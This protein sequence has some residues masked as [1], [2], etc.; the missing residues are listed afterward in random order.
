[1]LTLQVRSRT[2]EAEG[3]AGLVLT[4]P[5]GG[6]L[7]EW[8]PGAHIDVHIER[9]GA[10]ALV[11][12]YSLCGSPS[13][14]GAYRIAVLR[15]PEG[16]GGSRHLHDAVRQGQ[17]VRVSEPRNLFAYAAE[18]RAT[19]IAGGIGITPILPM[20]EAAEAAG[21]EWTLHYAG[22][23]PASMAFGRD[24][25]RY[26]ERVRVYASSEGERMAVPEIVAAAA[27]GRVYACGPGRLLDAVETAAEA[28]GVPAVVERFVNDAEI[29]SEADHPFEVE[30]ALTGTTI[31]VHPGESILDRVVELGVP[32]PSS[33]RGG[34]CGTC[35]TFV[36]AGEPDHRDAVLNAREREESEVM[37]IC[38]SRCR[39]KRL[40]LEL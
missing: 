39:G 28:A 12:Q 2:D 38:V 34:T 5:Q 37:M 29:V 23:E 22:R 36:L 21:A 32:A 31:T 35:E 26:G 1:M 7:P 3:I 9:P 20:L 19:F 11:R 27:P 10:P 17:L 25:A 15:E 14:R 30:L 8:L 24:L 33:C 4:D 6:E 16:E 40:R 13:D 18:E